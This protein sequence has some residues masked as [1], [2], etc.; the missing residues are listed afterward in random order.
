M[1]AYSLLRRDAVIL[2]L[3]RGMPLRKVAAKWNIPAS[4]VERIYAT[5]QAL[6]AERVAK[7]ARVGE[8]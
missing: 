6:I 2:A 4:Q 5:K 8:A 3:D 1:N 7:L